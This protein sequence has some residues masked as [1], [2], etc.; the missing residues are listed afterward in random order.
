MADW[1]G[2]VTDSTCDIPDA[3]LE[4]Y[5]IRVVPHVIIWGEEQF[6]DRVDLQP[7]DFYRRL[8]VDPVYPSSSQAGENDF[9]QVFEETASRGAKAI[10][11]VTVSSA[12]SGAF[13]MAQS[14]AKRMSIPVAV[15]DAK[16]PSLSV[17]WQALAAARAQEAG[18]DLDGILKRLET[19]RAGL[20][21]FVAMDSLEYLQKGGRIGGA[22]KW[23]GGLLQVKPLVS[24][25]H[26]TG[27]VE[28]VGLAR[29]HK[30]LVEMMVSQF[31]ARLAGGKNLRVAVLHGNAPKEAAQL[32]ERTRAEFNPLELLVNITG[33]VL[34]INTGPGALALCG[35]AEG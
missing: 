15:V 28:P 19:V 17:G 26:Q 27:L 33:P 21:Q 1:I 31:F 2:V 18:E 16:G 11:A 23:L 22:V 25:N 10:V 8:V 29:T 34:G 6:R 3:L 13:Q 5:A 9:L 35:Y 7:L 30:A 4:Q 20:A 32:A 24:I 12:M 14:A